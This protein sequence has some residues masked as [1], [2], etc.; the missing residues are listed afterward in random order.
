MISRREA[1]AIG[2]GAFLPKAVE[3]ERNYLNDF[4]LIDLSNRYSQVVPPYYLT[5]LS[6]DNL[7]L[8]CLAN[9]KAGELRQ[10]KNDIEV[11]LEKCESLTDLNSMLK[12]MR[13]H[14]YY[15]KD[16]AFLFKMDDKY[17]CL[18]IS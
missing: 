1:I 15:N 2:A 18:L 4:S 17:G 12:R 7:T 16:K 3:V 8:K 6:G 14:P 5:S 9:W 11:L 10:I 13:N